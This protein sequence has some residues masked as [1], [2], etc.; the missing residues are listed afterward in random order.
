[1]HLAMVYAAKTIPKIETETL[2]FGR[3]IKRLRGSL[4]ITIY[5]YP[6]TVETF[7]F[8]YLSCQFEFCGNGE[9]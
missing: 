3:L 1:M 5:I 4:K 9:L 6:L 2:S 8:P 7:H